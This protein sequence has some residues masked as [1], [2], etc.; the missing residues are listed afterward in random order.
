VLYIGVIGLAVRTKLEDEFLI[1]KLGGY[2]DYA[3][4]TRYRLVP[5]LW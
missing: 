1:A 3:L 2:E 5:G 4:T